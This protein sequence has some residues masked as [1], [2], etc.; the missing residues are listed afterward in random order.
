MLTMIII[1][2]QNV[3]NE[4]EE[5][6]TSRDYRVAGTRWFGILVIIKVVIKYCNH[7]CSVVMIVIFIMV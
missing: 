4:I 6:N 1:L 2:Q 7:H 5:V 3:G